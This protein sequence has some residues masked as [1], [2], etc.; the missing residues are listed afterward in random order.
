MCVR[1][2]LPLALVSMMALSV[3]GQEAARETEQR[4]AQIPFQ[5]VFTVP[6]IEFSEEQHVR[7]GELREEFIPQLT[8]F[9]QGHCGRCVTA[10]C[11]VLSHANRMGSSRSA[12]HVGAASPLVGGQWTPMTTPSI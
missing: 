5:A 9:Q 10:R 7:V 6:G 11:A 3:S 12:I 8:K 2:A 1:L 4:P